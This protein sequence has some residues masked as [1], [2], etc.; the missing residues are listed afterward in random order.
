MDLT[1]FLVQFNDGAAFYC[2]GE[3]VGLRTLGLVC[4]AV[5]SPG[6]LVQ[7]RWFQ[8][9]I[10]HQFNRTD[11]PLPG[12]VPPPGVGVDGGASTVILSTIVMV[13]AVLVGS[14]GL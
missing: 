13:F 12:L 10:P 7:S 9:W 11:N 1:L 14:M 3:L 8:D 2:D 6:V 4:N 5:D